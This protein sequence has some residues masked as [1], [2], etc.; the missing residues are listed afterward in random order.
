MKRVWAIRYKP[1]GDLVFYYRTLRWKKKKAL[2]SEER[3]AWDA[4]RNFIVKNWEY[5]RERDFE[6]FPIGNRRDF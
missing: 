1:T 6:V 4:I 3:F 2:F 5:A